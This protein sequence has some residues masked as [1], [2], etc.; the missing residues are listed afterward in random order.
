MANKVVLPTIAILLV[1]WLVAPQ[2]DPSTRRIK[3]EDLNGIWTTS[4]SEYKDRFLEFDDGMITF[5]RG[6][7]GTASYLIDKIECENVGESLLVHIRYSDTDSTDY[8]I[9]F[10][11]FDRHGGTLRL[12]NQ[13]DVHWT[14]SRRGINR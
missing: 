14:R 9:S 6:E 7:A 12:K 4:S 1:W 11:Y 8:R 2:K 13:A 10:F 3:P 5:G